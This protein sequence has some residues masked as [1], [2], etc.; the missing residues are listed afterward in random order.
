MNW[1]ALLT[2]A[3]LL[4]A[5]GPLH[6]GEG[7]EVVKRTLPFLEKE[8]VDWMEDRGC[9]SCHQVPSMLRSLSGAA[10][11]GFDVDAAKL[12]KWWDWSVDWKNWQKAT[13]RTTE[14][15][16]AAGNVETMSHL[17]LGRHAA[18]KDGAWVKA[19]RDHLVK[20]RDTNGVW[21]AGGQLPSG[22]RPARETQEV[23]TMWALLALKSVKSPETPNEVFERASAWLAQGQPGKSTE[24]WT[25]RLLAQREFG[26]VKEADATRRALFSQQN[27]DGGWGWL[28]GEPSDA[29]GTGLALY[30]LGRSGSSAR[31]PA[32]GKAIEFLKSSQAPDGSWAV[33]STRAKDNKKVRETSTYW[34][35]AWAALGIL[36]TLPRGDGDP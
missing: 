36:E 2:V 3:L 35:T 26:R 33:P 7:R 13:N 12:V 32:L 25:A 21:K 10:R 23:T 8:G 24:W 31:E 29:F 22:R 18:D 4:G 30:A 28:V 1:F 9:V 14:A 11:V 19:F 17:L 5:G 15:K 20:L 27:A 16:S 6:G 34:G